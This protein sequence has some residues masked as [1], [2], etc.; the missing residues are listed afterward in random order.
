MGVVM[1]VVMVIVM[2]MVTVAVTWER[3]LS[4]VGSSLASAIPVMW[5]PQGQ[6]PTGGRG[7]MAVVSGGKVGGVVEV[8]LASEGGTGGGGTVAS[9]PVSLGRSGGE[10]TAGGAWG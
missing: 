1:G 4:M 10:D 5:L 2:V 8:V 6:S 9:S 7:G 3:S